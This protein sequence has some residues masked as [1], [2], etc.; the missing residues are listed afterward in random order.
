[1]RY[2]LKLFILV[3]SEFKNQVKSIPII[4]PALKDKYVMTREGLNQLK[5]KYNNKFK[6][7]I[8]EGRNW[9]R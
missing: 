4:G 5:L 7:E 9:Y 6:K 2:E 8:S 1:M 3:I